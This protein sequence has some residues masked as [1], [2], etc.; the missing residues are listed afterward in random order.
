M[1]RPQSSKQLYRDSYKQCTL[2]QRRRKED[3]IYFHCFK[4]RLAYPKTIYSDTRMLPVCYPDHKPPQNLQVVVRH[5][6]CKWKPHRQTDNA[7]PG[8]RRHVGQ[9]ASATTLTSNPI[10][11]TFDCQQLL[12]KQ[13]FSRETYLI[14]FRVRHDWITHCGQSNRLKV[15]SR[16]VVRLK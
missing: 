12:K 9:Q 16:Q 14:S 4:N 3:K 2:N 11:S 5:T 10:K 7:L 15:M 13:D 1:T 6:D 8:K